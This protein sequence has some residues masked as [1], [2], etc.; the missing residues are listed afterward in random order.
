MKYLA[1]DP[2]DP[3]FFVKHLVLKGMM[4]KILPL[5]PWEKVLVLF[6]ARK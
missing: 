5:S 6:L 1:L 2:N 4:P 3:E